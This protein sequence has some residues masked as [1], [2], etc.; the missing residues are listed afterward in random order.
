MV[1]H[2]RVHHGVV[3][4]QDDVVLDEGQEVIVVATQFATD[5]RSRETLQRAAGSWS[6]DADE[7]DLYLEWNRQQRKGSRPEVA[8]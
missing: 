6:A 7:L 1:I 3:V 8:G 4:L 5:T 2:G